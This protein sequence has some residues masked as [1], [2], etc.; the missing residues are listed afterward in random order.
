MRPRV[1]FFTVVLLAVSG[2]ALLPRA[3]KADTQCVAGN[4]ASVIGTTCDIG[5]LQ[6]SFTSFSGSNESIDGS[7]TLSYSTWDAN[8]F[9]FTPVA[10]GFTISLG[11]GEES[12]TAPMSDHGIGETVDA[13]VLDFDV[14]DTTGDLTGIAVDP[15]TLSATGSNLA[16][17]SASGQVLCGG[18]ASELSATVYQN[19]NMPLVSDEDELSGSPFSSGTGNNEIF[20]LNAENGDSASWSGATTYTFDTAPANAPEPSTLLT[21]GI[22][23]ATLLGAAL[24]RKR[25]PAIH[26]RIA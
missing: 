24:F 7:L 13:A 14:T 5:S 1:R 12:I 3:A 11:S 9:T 18:C 25:Q 8:Q 4:L 2:L 26:P 6:I 21:L 16:E 17:A 15:G 10:G 22:G 23:L 20:L 19:E